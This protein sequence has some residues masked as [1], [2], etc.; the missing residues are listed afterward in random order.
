LRRANARTPFPRR[1]CE[2][3]DPYS[4]HAEYP[5]RCGLSLPS[6][7]SLEYWIARLR[8]RRRSRPSFRG[9]AKHRT[10]N[11]EIPRCAI[12][13]LRSGPSDHPGMTE[14]Q[15][16]VAS[17]LTK[18]RVWRASI[19]DTTSRPR[20]AMRPSRA[21]I[22]RPQRGRGECRMPA[23]PAASC[24]LGIGRKHTS[25]NEHTGIT[26]HSRTQWF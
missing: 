21:F 7:A 15:L 14:S 11:L 24:A 18:P 23:A 19:P 26:R 6:L 10:R 22:S 16:S 25:N 12:A 1:P 9:D 13:H 3:R 2:S 17:L 20:G 8:G 5:V 4:A